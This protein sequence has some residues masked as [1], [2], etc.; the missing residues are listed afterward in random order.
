MA[1]RGQGQPYMFRTAEVGGSAIQE[2]LLTMS[3]DVTRMVNIYYTVDWPILA[4]ALTV[5]AASLKSMLPP[6]GQ[7]LADAIISDSRAVHW[8]KKTK[9]QGWGG[10]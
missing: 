1:K 5:A 9:L 3:D 6:D 4:A 10:K 2:A 8:I 7:D